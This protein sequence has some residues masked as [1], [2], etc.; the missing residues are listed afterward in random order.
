MTAGMSRRDFLR[1]AIGTGAVAAVPPTFQR[2]LLGGLR[3]PRGTTAAGAGG[4]T[5][6]PAGGLFFLDPGRYATAT[7]I[8]ARIVPTG[9]NPADSPGATEAHAAAFID[10]FLAA[11]ELPAAV[12]DG[13][14][15]YVHG[16][17][18][19]RNPLPDNAT[20]KPS[21][22]FPPDDFLTVPSSGQPKFHAMPL[23]TYQALS[24]K[25]QLYGTSALASLPAGASPAWRSQVGGLI[26]APTGLRSLYHD[27]L[28]AF[29]DYSRQTFGVPFTQATPQEQDLM[30]EAAGNVV[31][32]QFPLPTPPGAPSEAKALFPS[33][34]IHTF[35]GCYG[36]PEYR[37]LNKDDSA[38]PTG[39]W[40]LIGWDGDTQPLGNSIYDESAFGPG[41]GPNQGFGDPAVFQPRGDYREYRP[42]S[43]LGPGD[44]LELAK[45]DLAPMVEALRRL[46]VLAHSATA[47][48]KGV[49]P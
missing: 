5:P 46:G 49:R 16:R 14:A 43:T 40:R 12:A 30:L 29:D 48:K 38:D 15:I 17:Y 32:S 13:P 47:G 1:A 35:Q 18:S 21:S 3:P 23:G 44:G 2:R 39:L 37:W 25:V 19:G 27:G 11:F 45:A 34:T 10:R 41:Q 7:A 20:G 22:T 36:L 4:A 33:I 24:W 8:C 9:A 28:K 6:L 42:V 26:P 31:V